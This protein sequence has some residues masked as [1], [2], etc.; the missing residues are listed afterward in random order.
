MLYKKRVVVQKK[1]NLL[2]KFAYTKNKHY[3][4]LQLINPIKTESHL[5]KI[6]KGPASLSVAH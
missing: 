2:P 1:L 3:N 5:Q 4:Y 6:I